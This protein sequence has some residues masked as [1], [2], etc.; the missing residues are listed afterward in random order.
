MSEQNKN[1]LPQNYVPKDEAVKPAPLDSDL[2]AEE[3]EIL[4]R[5][6]AELRKRDPFIYR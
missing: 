5:K 6:I 1:D 3:E 2:T 4:K